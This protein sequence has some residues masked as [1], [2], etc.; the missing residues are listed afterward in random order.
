MPI[1]FAEFLQSFA[2]AAGGSRVAVALL[3]A[4]SAYPD[5]G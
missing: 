5:N 4:S 3:F 2:S 1:S